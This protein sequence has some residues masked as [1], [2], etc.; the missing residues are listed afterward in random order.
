[1]VY[2][3]ATLSRVAGDEPGKRGAKKQ[4]PFSRE[5]GKRGYEVLN[6]S[7]PES[8]VPRYRAR[9]DTSQPGYMIP[10]RL[11]WLRRA[12]PS[13]T[14]H[15]IQVCSSDQTCLHDPTGHLRARQ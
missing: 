5:I 1:M 11:S 6:V 14:L 15:E 9:V 10:I 2:S 7:H 3:S 13:A 12:R 4:N 8:H